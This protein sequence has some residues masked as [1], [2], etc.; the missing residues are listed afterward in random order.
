M[1]RNIGKKGMRISALLCMIAL[2]GALLC[3]CLPEQVSGPCASPSAQ[4]V[5][6]APT[7]TITVMASPTATPQPLPSL[8]PSATPTPSP[9]PSPTPT[10]APTQEQVTDESLP[11][12]LVLRTEPEAQQTTGDAEKEDA[13]AQQFLDA[14]SRLKLVANVKSETFGPLQGADIT[15]DDWL[16]LSKLVSARL[17][18]DAV[19]GLVITHCPATMAETAYFLNLTVHTQKPVVLTGALDAHEE[20]ALYLRDAITVASNPDARDRGVLVCMRQTI[21]SARHCSAQSVYGVDRNA[22]ALGFVAGGNVSLNMRTSRI[23]TQESEFD[24]SAL[25]KLP[26][27]EIAWQYA[28]ASAGPLR[29]LMDTKPDGVVLGCVQGV[30]QET[31]A[32][33]QQAGGTVPVVR[34]S[35]LADGMLVRNGDAP[36]DALGTIAAGD[37]TCTQAR[38]LLMLALTKTQD[39]AEIQRMME[40]Y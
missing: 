7:P 35:A 14:V 25:D 18:D 22:G 15:S 11:T 38:I 1:Q 34:A 30:S 37:L 10:P 39:A 4:S 9:S 40:I 21:Y 5:V 32:V 3:G 16:A 13:A 12:I 19:D 20:G 29:Y 17:A 6:L 8:S 28:G 31:A 26:R 27:V 23:H 24:V 2:L 36:D 33:L